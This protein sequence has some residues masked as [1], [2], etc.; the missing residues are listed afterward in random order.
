ME[1][2]ETFNDV[3]VNLFRDILNVEE[4]ALKT[5]EYRNISGRDMHVLEAIGEGNSRNMSAVAAQLSVTVGTLTTAVNH[6]V[7][8][9]YVNRERS[10]KDRRV[11]LLSLSEKGKAA[12]FHHQE[13]HEEMVAAM[14]RNL[15][16]EE[17]VVLESALLKLRRFFR[18]Q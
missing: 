12:Y 18:E 15:N 5:S 16:H 6:L 4:K 2:Y 9:G 14:T 17:I 8:K 7:K 13:F 3:L 10:E 11:V 1:N